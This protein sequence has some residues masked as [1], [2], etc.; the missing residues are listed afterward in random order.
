MKKVVLVVAGLL[1]ALVS[2]AAD[3]SVDLSSQ[4][5]KLSYTVGYDMGQNFKNQGITI[6]PQI[7]VQGVQDG[8]SGTDGKM[9]AQEMQ[10]TIVSFQKQWI[11]KRADQLKQQAAD[12]KSEGDKYLAANKAKEGVE[13]LPNGLQYKVI[14]N[15]DG[16][17]PKDG[18]VVTVEYTG[19]FID[20]NVFD[21]SNK[22][23]SFAVED[24]IPAWS[25]AL[26]MMPIGSVWEV[27]APP[28]LAYGE[29]GVMNGAIGPNK[30]LIFEIHLL[31]IKDQEK[32]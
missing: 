12:N 13:T 16:A 1:V 11:A 32:S 3:N 19:R 7:L 18:D 8:L 28:S 21:K 23:V 6:D 30:T 9:S 26:K 20:G 22:P 17:K 27:V 29:Q 25:E 24:V 10:D 14:K 4:E 15:G 2:Y 5:S 31:G